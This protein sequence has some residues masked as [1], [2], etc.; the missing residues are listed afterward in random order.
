MVGKARAVEAVSH[1]YSPASDFVVMRLCSTVPTLQ[2]STYTIEI[3]GWQRLGG[4]H[5]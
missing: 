2:Y 1:T 3:A 5:H 4:L